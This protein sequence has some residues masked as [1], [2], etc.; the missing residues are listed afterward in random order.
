MIK[1]SCAY[2]VKNGKHVIYDA[3]HFFTGYE[4]DKEY[5]MKTLNAALEGG[6]EL[7][8]LCETRGG[9]M[10]HE[11]QKA[12]RDV[13]NTYGSKVKIGIHTHND[14]GLAVANSL[15][16]VEEGVCHVQGVL[17]GFGERTGNAIF[18]QFCQ[19]YSTKWAMNVFLQKNLKALLRF[20]RKFQK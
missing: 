16:A 14:C 11:V 3:E 2:L 4:A 1:E 7:L 18:L 6:A 10:V 8:C 13:V 9:S 12:V 5:A 15:V 17:L 20:V 19:T